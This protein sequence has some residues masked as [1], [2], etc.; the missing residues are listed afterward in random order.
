MEG[1]LSCRKAHFWS[2]TPK[3]MVGSLCVRVTQ[4]VDK[5]KIRAQIADLFKSAGISHLTVEVRFCSM[6]PVL[7]VSLQI[8]QT[9]VKQGSR[10]FDDVQRTLP[11]VLPRDNKIS[12]PGIS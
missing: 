10:D 2:F 3:T 7:M 12:L 8:I 5:Q 1:V 11:D 4:R 6:L 9:S